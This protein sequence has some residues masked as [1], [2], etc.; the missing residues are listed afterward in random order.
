MKIA[1]LGSSSQIAKGLLREFHNHDKHH[2]YL[3]TRDTESFNNWI[4]KISTQNEKNISWW[5]SAPAS[6]DE[7]ISNL[8]HNICILNTIKKIKKL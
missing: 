8:F 1:F 6:R 5:L 2:F 3:F 7:R 4:D